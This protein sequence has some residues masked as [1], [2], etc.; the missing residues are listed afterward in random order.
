MADGTEGRNQTTRSKEDDS[1]RSIQLRETKARTTGEDGKAICK[2]A[3][4]LQWVRMEEE[5]EYREAVEEEVNGRWEVD[6]AG[7]AEDRNGGIMPVMQRIG[8]R[9]SCRSS[10]TWRQKETDDHKREI[11]HPRAIGRC[12]N[13]T[14]ALSVVVVQYG[15]SNGGWYVCQDVVRLDQHPYTLPNLKELYR[16][17]FEHLSAQA[18]WNACERAGADLLVWESYNIQVEDSQDW[19]SETKG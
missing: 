16:F 7:N 18:K 4:K 9:G 17:Q 19:R 1:G 13:V 12:S 8:M 6:H 11:S 10:G 14:A 2:P 15:S 5:G 3:K